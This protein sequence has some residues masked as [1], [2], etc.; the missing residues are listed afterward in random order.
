MNTQMDKGGLQARLD[1]SPFDRTLGL[2]VD[3]VRSEELRLIMDWSPDQLGDPHTGA[4][5]GGAAGS[6]IDVA[7]AALVVS[8]RGG[9]VATIDFNITFHRPCI[10]HR[11]HIVARLLHLG[12]RVASV[13]VQLL[14][15]AAKLLATGR[16]VYMLQKKEPQ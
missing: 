3:V 15:A 2:S 12:R 8:R 1:A 7:G 16:S 13:E 9:S 4:L 11:I 10:D 14:T 6:V 5:H